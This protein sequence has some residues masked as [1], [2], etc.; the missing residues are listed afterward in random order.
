MGNIDCVPA[1]RIIIYGIEICLFLVHFTQIVLSR[2]EFG[3]LYNVYQ[4]SKLM[5]NSSRNFVTGYQ[6][7]VVIE[8]LLVA[9]SLHFIFLS[10]V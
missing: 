5:K 10:A 2:S 4:G 1:Q 3:K 8:Q 9:K 7:L 6:N